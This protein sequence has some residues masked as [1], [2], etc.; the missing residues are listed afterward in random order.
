MGANIGACL[1]KDLVQETIDD[2]FVVNY[3]WLFL[4]TLQT[5]LPFGFLMAPINIVMFFVVEVYM[6]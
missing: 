5:F 6:N 4:A 2:Y 1:N 3:V